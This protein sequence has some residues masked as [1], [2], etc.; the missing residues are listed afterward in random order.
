MNKVCSHICYLDK[1]ESYSSLYGQCCAFLSLV[2]NNDL[3]FND[4][5]V[6]GLK[7]RNKAL[8]N[9]VFW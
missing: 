1:E 5:H 9:S 4:N 6:K 2:L 7:Y 8:N 3:S